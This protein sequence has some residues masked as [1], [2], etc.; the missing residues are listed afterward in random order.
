[1]MRHS[2]DGC[3]TLRVFDHVEFNVGYNFDI[4]ISL[5]GPDRLGFKAIE[6]FIMKILNKLNE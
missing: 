1:M 5:A 4:W 6:T 2:N 3:L